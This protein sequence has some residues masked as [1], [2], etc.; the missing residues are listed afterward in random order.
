MSYPRA[1]ALCEKILKH[2]RILPFLGGNKNTFG[3]GDGT[4]PY[5]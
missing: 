3:V 5:T 1:R 2:I 4:P